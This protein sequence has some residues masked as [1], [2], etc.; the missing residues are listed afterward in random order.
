MNL[1]NNYYFSS[2]FWSTFQKILSAIL[3]FISVPLLLG[4]YGK[5]DYGILSIATACN[6]YMHLLDLGMNTGAIKFFS[7]WRAEGKNELINRVA[8]TNVSFY[9]IISVINSIGLIALAQFGESFFSITHVQFLQLQMC[10]YI[11]A[12]LSAFSW[13]TTAFN[14]IIVAEKQISFTMQMQCVQILLKTILIFVVLW[15]ELSLTVYFLFLNIIIAMLII[16]YA[17]KCKRDGLIESIKPAAYWSDFRAVF[18]FSLSIFAL[19]LFQM[20]ATYTRPVI[21]GMFAEDGASSVTDFSIISVFPN[22]II[23]IGG[24]FSGI[25]LPKTSEMVARGNLAEQ[26]Q[27][28]YKWT[29]LTTIVVNGL[30]FPFIIGA[31]D[32]ISAYVGNQNAYLSQWL[33]IWVVCTLLQMHSTPTNA[34]I[35][36]YGRTKM[37]VYISGLACVLSMVINALLA[38]YYSLGSAVIGYAVY[39]ILNLTVYYCYYYHK[40]LGISNFKIVQ[41]FIYPTFCGITA[42][43]IASFIASYLY[44]NI[45]SNERFNYLLSFGI[46]A[47]IWY[48]LFFILILLFKI[49]KIKDKIVLTKYDKYY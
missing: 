20:T 9:L 42:Y 4:Y 12:L 44:L 31:S 10:L 7:Q 13:V 17:Y 38:R 45:V 34:L 27:F 23:M 22:L 14:Q 15:A 41:S 8:R 24:T 36:G 40:A 11:I 47:C 48:V 28:A 2:F 25:F 37:M 29:I 19:S 21:L 32:I 26:H 33:I 3:G 16:P 6:G 35:L 30:C 43:L 1:K 5:P 18:F 39:I 49:I 46:K